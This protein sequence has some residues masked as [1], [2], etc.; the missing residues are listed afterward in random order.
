MMRVLASFWCIGVMACARE[1]RDSLGRF[2]IPGP[3]HLWQ[4]QQS[5]SSSSSFI[6]DTSSYKEEGGINNAPST[7]QPLAAGTKW[8][9]CTIHPGDDTSVLF[10][11]DQRTLLGYREKQDKGP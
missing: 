9:G 7:T 3:L 6:L 5:V 4:S 8:S 10:M 11:A 2:F 1:N